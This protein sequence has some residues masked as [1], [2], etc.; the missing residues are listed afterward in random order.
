M[1]INNNFTTPLDIA[2]S[3]LPRASLF[4]ALGSVVHNGTPFPVREGDSMNPAL[5]LSV[6]R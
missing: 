2:I 1:L 6:L 3:M 5:G 4:F